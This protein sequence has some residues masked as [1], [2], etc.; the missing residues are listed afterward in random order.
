MPP[1]PGQGAG[2]VPPAGFAPLPASLRALLN[3]TMPPQANAGLMFQRY[4]ALWRMEEGRHQPVPSE[5]R[6]A[7]I[8]NFTRDFAAQRAVREPELRAQLNRLDALSQR[9]F[10]YT[11][12]FRMVTGIGAAHPL[13]NSFTFDHLLGVPKLAGS[14]VKGLLRA[15]ANQVA[16]PEEM[17]PYFGNFLERSLAEQD[18]QRRTPAEQKA[19]TDARAGDVVFL[20]AFPESWPVLEVDILNP[21]HSAYMQERMK[22]RDAIPTLTEDPVPVYFLTIAAGTPFRFG[23]RGRTTPLTE[24]ELARTGAWLTG[25]LEWMGAGAKT[26]AGYGHMMPAQPG[27]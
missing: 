21:H 12:T 23:V 5:S 22:G 4:P 27:R 19:L 26:A 1:A 11:T 17:L 7:W 15:F 18:G 16:A 9:T 3:P 20:D 25:A 6:K 8:E 2:H 10:R 13:E 24:A 14:G